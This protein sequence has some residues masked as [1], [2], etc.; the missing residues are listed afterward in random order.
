MK[1]RDNFFKLYGSESDPILKTIKLNNFKK[2]RNFVI[3]KKEESKKQYYQSHFQKFP[4]T[5]KKLQMEVN[6]LLA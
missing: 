1:K 3:S 5:L 6:Q 4:Q 2:A